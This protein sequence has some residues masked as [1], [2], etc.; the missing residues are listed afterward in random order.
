MIFRNLFLV[1]LLT[2]FLS[3][4]AMSQ[5]SDPLRQAWVRVETPNKALSLEFPSDYL[6]DAEKQ[7]NF[8][9]F[10]LNGPIGPM[11][12]GNVPTLKDYY[13]QPEIMAFANNVQ[14][15]LQTYQFLQ[16]G[17]AKQ[18]LWHFIPHEKI[19]GA[20]KD[21][22]MDDIFLRSYLYEKDAY[23]HA[24]FYLTQGTKM[25]VIT[26][27]TKD[28]DDP[29]FGRFV[30]SIM[31]RGKRIVKNGVT[32]PDAQV[33]TVTLD[34]LKA[35][36]EIAAA[37]DRKVIE[38]EAV[39]AKTELMLKAKDPDALDLYRPVVLL[40]RSD[41]TNWQVVE[42]AQ[43]EVSLRVTFLADGTIGDI[44][45]EKSWSKKIDKFCVK[46]TRAMKFLPA[47]IDGKTIDLVKTVQYNFNKSGSY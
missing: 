17:S 15:R 1:S 35:S 10:T 38:K 27:Y 3:W 44:F 7:D 11:G 41:Q 40:R 36:P 39:I 43:G 32:D 6:V 30:R 21:L 16:I 13:L 20:V 12:S 26:A 25:Y 4:S 9:A 14:L 23:F 18:V 33:Q 22:K 5:T 8:F 46:E 28:K 34:S 29:T 31:V 45:V 37:L 2:A 19:D 24:D 42:A 47:I